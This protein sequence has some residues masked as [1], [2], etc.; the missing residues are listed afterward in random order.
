[1]F[2]KIEFFG[3]GI[4]VIQNTNIATHLKILLQNTLIEYAA[5]EKIEILKICTILYYDHG[6]G[7]ARCIPKIHESKF[8]SSHRRQKFITDFQSIMRR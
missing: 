2:K 6:K 8:V 1:M 3:L 7:A 5:L 4:D